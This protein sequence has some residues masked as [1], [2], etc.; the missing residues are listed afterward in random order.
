[1]I[2]YGRGDSINDYEGILGHEEFRGDLAVMYFPALDAAS[3][4]RAGLKLKALRMRRFQLVPASSADA[5][6]MRQMFERESSAV[7]ERFMPCPDGL[8]LS[9]PAGGLLMML[10]TPPRWFAERSDWVLA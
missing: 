1:M 7:G 8:T 4:D 6:W 2:P 10:Q 3:G 5:E 9:R